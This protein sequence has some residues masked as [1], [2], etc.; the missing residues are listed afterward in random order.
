[1]TRKSVLT[2][3]MT[4]ACVF[5]V[6]MATYG[7]EAPNQSEPPPAITTLTYYGHSAFQINTPQGNV[8]MID[9]WL[10]NPLNPNAQDDKSP[11]ANIRKLD[12]ILITH[13]HYD[14]VGD[15]VE[16]TKKTGAR[17]VASFE[18]GGNMSH[19]L[20]FP[21]THIR[22]DDLMN[23][24][25]EITIADGEVMVAMTPALHSSGMQNP[26]PGRSQSLYV[27]GGTP[28]GFV[29]AIKN[30]PTI[31]HSG[32][33]AYFKDMERIGEQ[34][35]PDVAL[36][37]IGGHFTMDGPMAAKAA[38]AVKAKLVIPDHYATFPVLASDPSAFIEA[39]KEKQINYLIMKPG[40]TIRFKGKELDKN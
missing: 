7:T 38:E 13:A 34:Y 36:L 19:V 12:Y 31:Y 6:T 35:A 26:S 1:M 11:F 5:F 20:G 29:L 27:Y 39:A 9:P 14:H 40:E 22:Y 8:L 3:A 17:L 18:L 32:D 23:I 37:P 25:G 15:A 10:T 16:L 21:N 24:G 33:T 30:G 28:A 4:M 2:F